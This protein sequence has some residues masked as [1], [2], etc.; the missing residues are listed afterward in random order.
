VEQAVH[1]LGAIL[2]RQQGE[3][4]GAQFTA[5]TAPADDDAIAC[6]SVFPALSSVQ[7]PWDFTG[8]TG[9][10]PGSWRKRRR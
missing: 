9:E 3:G 8:A 7:V 1:D 6:R 2:R 10:T 4:I 5:A